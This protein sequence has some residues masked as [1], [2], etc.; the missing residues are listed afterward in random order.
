MYMAL[1]GRA[2]QR[3][4][5]APQPMQRSILIAGIFIE[6]RLWASEGIICIA[7]VGQW[8]AQLPH[9][10]PSVSG[11]QFFFIHTA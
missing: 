10:K 5:Q 1:N 11:M 6:S 8:R 7:P 4:S 2:G 3:F 9:S